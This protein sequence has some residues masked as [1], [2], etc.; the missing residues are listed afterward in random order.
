MKTKAGNIL[1]IDD[2]DYVLKTIHQLLKYEC[3]AIHTIKNP[4]QIHSILLKES[5]DVIVLDMNFKAG[6]NSG[7]EGLFWLDEILKIDKNAVVIMIT[8]Y[9]DIELAVKAIKK[10]ATDFI[11]K[12]W[13]AEKFITTVL[14]AIKISQS[15]RKNE[16]LEIRQE[17]LNKDI[18]KPFENFI[19]SSEKMKDVFSL[20]EKVSKTDANIL[21]LGEN[22]TGKELIAREIHKRSERATEIFMTVDIASMSESIIESELFGYVKG[23]FTDAREDRIGRFESASGGTL[24]LDEIG[25]LSLSMQAKLLNVLQSRIIY[26]VGS[27][28]EIPIDVRL[29]CATNNNIEKMIE[30]GEFREDL[31]YRINTIQ[32]QSPPL[33]E[34]DL[35]ILELAQFYLNKFTD[36]YN[37]GNMQV[38]KDAQSELLS[39]PWKG[40]VRELM[41]TI[42]KAVILSDKEELNSTDFYLKSSQEIDT[43]NRSNKLEDVEKRII[44]EVLEKHKWNLTKTANE[45]AI[46]RTTLYLKLKKYEIQ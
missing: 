39:Y 38:S 17:Q 41:H 21:I 26:K 44:E 31:Y 16:I 36:K 40:N 14:N 20:I 9:G 15:K 8:A 13:E 6:V 27:S 33:R 5:F 23:A 25:N 18:N 30:Q 28:K 10:G 42:E 3:E 37:K 4:N 34:R 7:N 2:N 1:V 32:I 11:T 45:L 12:P 19:G 35:D 24:F 43:K 46:S 29:I 22:G